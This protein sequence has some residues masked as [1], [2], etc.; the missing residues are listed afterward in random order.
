[1]ALHKYVDISS[2]NSSQE[3]QVPGEH[4]D[5]YINIYVSSVIWFGISKT[6]HG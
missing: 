2:E 1:L 5:K 3:K 4:V 6:F